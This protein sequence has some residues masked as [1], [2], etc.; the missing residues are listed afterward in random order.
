M[1]K[2]IR[3]VI[4]TSVFCLS[5]GVLAGAQIGSLIKGGA[6]A[7]AVD[8]FG[9][10]INKAINKLTGEKD[11]GPKEATKV[12]PIISLGDSGYIGAV[13][14]AGPRDKVD[15]VKAVVQLEGRFKLPIIDK[16][17]LRGLVPVA[18]KDAKE[19]IKRVE[20]VGVSAIIDVKI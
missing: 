6:V 12:V 16:I 2:T 10:D 4:G 19:G 9:P 8:K 13:Q 17:R 11:M 5:I 1:N 7:V 3:L 20:G 18:S 15:S 14:V